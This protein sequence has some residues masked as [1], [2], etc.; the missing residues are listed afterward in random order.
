M[1][2][3]V[4]QMLSETSLITALDNCTDNIV[5]TCFLVCFL[6]W[7]FCT[8]DVNFICIVICEGK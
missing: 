6:H 1:I 2:E 3:K 5:Y 7:L 4:N 8:F